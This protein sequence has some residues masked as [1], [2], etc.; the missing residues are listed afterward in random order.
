LAQEHVELRAL[1]SIERLEDGVL[2]RGEG[3]LGIRQS[4]ATRVG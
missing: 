3:E 4:L 2:D 1:L